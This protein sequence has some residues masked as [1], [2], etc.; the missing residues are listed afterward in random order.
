MNCEHLIHLLHSVVA[1]AKSFSSVLVNHFALFIFVLIVCHLFVFLL[2][3]RPLP[4]FAFRIP[5]CARFF[6]SLQLA[7]SKLARTLHEA[8]CR[9]GVTR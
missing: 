1:A 2:N 9:G 7:R 3:L 6:A 4:C 5:H 8:S